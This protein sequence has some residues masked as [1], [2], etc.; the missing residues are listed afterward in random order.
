M[1]RIRRPYVAGTFYAGDPD[2]LKEQ[3]SECFLGRLG[4]GEVPTPTGKLGEPAG[5]ISPHAGYQY[6][7]QVAA[8]GFHF[9]SEIGAPETVVVIGTNHTGLGS[10]ISIVTEGVW[11][12]P[13]GGV[14]VDSELARSIAKSPLVAEGEEAFVREHSIE[15]QLPFLQY[16][17]KAFRFVPICC[18]DQ[19]METSIELGRT[20]AEAVRGKSVALIAS[21]D[22]T[23]YESHDLAAQKDKDAIKRVLE[24][25]VG[26]FYESIKRHSTSICGYGPIAALVEAAKA[27]QLKDVRLL[28]YSTSG[29]VTGMRSEVVG[30][31]SISFRGGE[32]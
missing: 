23:H 27:L 24:L 25:D 20:L 10:P 32:R 19:R 28:K 8:H 3:I 18:L 4:P 7:G 1:N 9:L 12:T 5:V 22:F 16:L 14:E 26:S 2:S 11:E 29:D 17:F 21:S 13:L 15:V 31:A 30:Y 6:S